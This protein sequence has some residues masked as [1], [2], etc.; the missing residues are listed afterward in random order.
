MSWFMPNYRCYADR[1]VKWNEIT[2]RE[3]HPEMQWGWVL[4]EYDE[5]TEAYNARN[6]VSFLKELCDLFVVTSYYIYLTNVDVYTNEDL[7]KAGAT[8]NN[9]SLDSSIQL[10]SDMIVLGDSVG[11]I[12]IVVN[13]L[14]KLDAEVE[15]ALSEVNSSNFSKFEVFI[16]GCEEEYDNSAY[17]IEH[18]SKGRYT[19]VTWKLSNNYVIYVSGEGKILKGPDYIEANVSKYVH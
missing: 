19:G 6:K 10:L 1:V 4:E 13:I 17:A 14:N 2:G 9:G 15:S 7:F 12:S 8:Y 18:G 16:P 3:V 5:L 11:I